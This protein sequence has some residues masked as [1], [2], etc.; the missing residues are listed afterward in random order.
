MMNEYCQTK[1]QITRILEFYSD[2]NF[3]YN[4]YDCILYHHVMIEIKKKM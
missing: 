4:C 1:R 3:P 2:Y